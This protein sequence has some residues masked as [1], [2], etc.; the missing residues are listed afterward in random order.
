MEVDAQ[1][2][3]ESCLGSGFWILFSNCIAAGHGN[4]AVRN[5]FL[6][7][8]RLSG[9]SN[10]KVPIFTLGFKNKFKKRHIITTTICKT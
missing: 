8:C 4:T 1:A 6:S 9:T 2:C 3:S 5:S 10:L 7:F